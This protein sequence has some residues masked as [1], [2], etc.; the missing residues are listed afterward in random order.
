MIEREATAAE[1][2][3]ICPGNVPARGWFVQGF[4]GRDIAALWNGVYDDGAVRL[5]RPRAYQA[6]DVRFP[7]AQGVLSGE[8]PRFE[9]ANE[10]AIRAD[11]ERRIAANIAASP[12][13]VAPPP[14][15]AVDWDKY[16]RQAKGPAPVLTP[17]EQKQIDAVRASVRSGAA[18]HRANATVA[19]RSSGLSACVDR[20]LAEARASTRQG[21]RPAPQGS[22]ES[23]MDDY[24]AQAMGGAR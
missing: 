7:A 8:V 3:E 16:I 18:K 19:Q 21:A 2:A 22:A 23:R 15:P 4:E 11:I 1:W 14:R 17:H 13:P 5:T 12:T 24:I 10:L 20:A 9:S 6:R